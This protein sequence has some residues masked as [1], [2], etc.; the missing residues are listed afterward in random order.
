MHN[1]HINF[2]LTL[3]LILSFDVRQTL[4]IRSI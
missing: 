2:P 1:L 4:K 3:H